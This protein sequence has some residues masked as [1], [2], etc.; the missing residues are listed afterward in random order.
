VEQPGP[1]DIVSFETDQAVIVLEEGQY[2]EKKTWDVFLT[3]DVDNAEEVTISRGGDVLPV[4]NVFSGSYTDEITAL[5]GEVVYTLSATNQANETV[6]EEI[7][8]VVEV[9]GG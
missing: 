1:P 3:W 4:G 7:S 5:P 9:T 8:V 2:G 6:T